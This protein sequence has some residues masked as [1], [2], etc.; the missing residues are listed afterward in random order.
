MPLPAFLVAGFWGSIAT[1]VIGITSSIIGVIIRALGFGLVTY[2]GIDLVTDYGRDWVL[3]QFSGLPSD[4]LQILYLL[5]LDV[6][7]KMVFAAMSAALV[8]KAAKTSVGD[9]SSF[10]KPTWRKPGS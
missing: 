7:F 1:F 4:M 3:N 5:K 9:G 8:L 10:T 6:G 2:Y